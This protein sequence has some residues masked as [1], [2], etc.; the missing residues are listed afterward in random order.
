MS[1]LGKRLDALEQLAADIRLREQD[2]ILRTLAAERG[3]PPDL[4]L[5]GYREVRAQNAALRAQGFTE[6]QIIEATAQRIGCTVAELLAGR[7][8]LVERFG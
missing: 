5:E 2:Q 6:A 1:T 4:L 7:D 8:A 3:I